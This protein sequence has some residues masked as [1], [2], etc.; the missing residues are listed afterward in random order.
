MLKYCSCKCKLCKK[1][2]VK[3]KTTICIPHTAEGFFFLKGADKV[4][5][6]PLGGS[7]E[8]CA[9]SRNPQGS[10]L[11][12]TPSRVKSQT[13]C[14]TC[15]CSIHWATSALGK[16]KLCKITLFSSIDFFVTT[17]QLSPSSYLV[18]EVYL[19]QRKLWS[20]SGQRRNPYP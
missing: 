6:F 16:C 8:R 13:F 11:I 19:T 18:Y 5:Q 12:P 14:S 4:Y 15:R 3:V 17:W 1:V 9:Q 20:E 2:K 10:Q 7:K